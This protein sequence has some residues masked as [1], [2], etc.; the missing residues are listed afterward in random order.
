MKKK[1]I[2]TLCF[3]NLPLSAQAL[4]FHLINRCN[5]EG[6]IDNGH[7]NAV[8]KII[9]AN[10]FDLCHLVKSKFIYLYPDGVY[11][12]KEVVEQCKCNME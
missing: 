5:D 4:Y 10:S 3:C 11:V 7:V 1:V 9:R 12:V 6:F 2:N 8:V